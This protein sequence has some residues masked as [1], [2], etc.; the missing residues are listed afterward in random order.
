VVPA[1]QEA[2]GRRIMV[3]T[4]MGKNMKLYLKKN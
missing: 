3:P 4:K 2:I 1:T